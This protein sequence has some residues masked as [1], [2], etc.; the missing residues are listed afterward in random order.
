[1]GRRYVE[2]KPSALWDFIL[3][4][5]PRG[6]SQTGIVPLCQRRER[7][8]MFERQQV[9][10]YGPGTQRD[11]EPD[12]N[13]NLKRAASGCISMILETERMSAECIKVGAG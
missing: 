12:L 3:M 6:Q 4:V 2:V 8:Q 11:A 13:A 1:M 9:Q 7:G 5:T 10:W